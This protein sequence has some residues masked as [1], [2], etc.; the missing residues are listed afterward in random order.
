MSG[1]RRTQILQGKEWP[2]GFAVRTRRLYVIARNHNNAAD[3]ACTPE[4]I[5]LAWQVRLIGHLAPATSSG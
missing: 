2:Q 4:V 3:L 1:G 5:L